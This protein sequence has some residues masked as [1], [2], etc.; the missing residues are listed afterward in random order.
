[1]GVGEGEV[2]TDGPFGVVALDLRRAGVDRDAAFARA[3]ALSGSCIKVVSS[4]RREVRLGL[5]STRWKS[6]RSFTDDGPDCWSSE[7]SQSEESSSSSMA[8]SETS[9][10]SSSDPN[11]E[12]YSAAFATATSS[13]NAVL[14]LL[15]SLVKLLGCL[16]LSEMLLL[17]I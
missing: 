15:P 17:N 8:L 13:L 12:L 11:T 7:S 1:M 4:D 9:S 6:S 16:R 14:F 3:L 10:S 5:E 2:A